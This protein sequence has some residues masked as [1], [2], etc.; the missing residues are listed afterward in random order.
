[1]DARER[2][3]VVALIITHFTR[4]IRYELEKERPGTAVLFLRLDLAI[5]NDA[6][7]CVR[8]H[9]IIFVRA[10][11]LIPFSSPS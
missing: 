1:M 11:N 6:R 4:A 3:Q 2:H 8:L 9:K 7:K 5:A 10:S